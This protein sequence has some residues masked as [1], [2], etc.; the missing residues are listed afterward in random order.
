MSK[1]S[2]DCL[3]SERTP[4]Q[5]Q[6]LA[7]DGTRP[8]LETR[9][10]WE[11]TFGPIPPGLFV[12]HVCDNPRCINTQH[13]FLGTPLDNMRDKVAKGRHH[14]QQKTHCPRGHEYTP[15]NTTYGKGSQGRKCKECRRGN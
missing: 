5:R 3:L 8:R 6:P 10:V 7:W 15:E 12:C 13:L 11:T 1:Y 4:S 14:N 9:M 2:T